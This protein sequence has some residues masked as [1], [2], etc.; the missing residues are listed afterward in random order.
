[1]VI[2]SGQVQVEVPIDSDE[3]DEYNK[4][5]RRCAGSFMT[6]DSGN[7]KTVLFVFKRGLVCSVPPFLILLISDPLCSVTQLE[8]AL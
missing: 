6:E 1:M 8:A 3:A 5:L 4:D 7:A 2:T